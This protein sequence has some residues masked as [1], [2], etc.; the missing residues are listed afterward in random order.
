MKFEDIRF[1]NLSEYHYNLH[2]KQS[3][4]IHVHGGFAAVNRGADCVQPL[5]PALRARIVLAMQ[6]KLIY[7]P[8]IP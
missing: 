3:C 5:V 1:Y 8:V 6:R 4:I 7:D 2:D